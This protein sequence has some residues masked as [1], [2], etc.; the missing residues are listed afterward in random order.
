MPLNERQR[1]FVVAY[2]KTGIA[3]RS[4]KAAGYEVTSRNALDVNAS[5]LLRNDKIQSA[6]REKRRQMLKRSDITL[7]KLLSDIAEARALAMSSA[8]PS[9]AIAASQL[10]AKL[11][12]LLVDRKESGAPG[13]FA[14]L[15]TPQQV[16]DAI[17]AELG[18]AAADVLQAAVARPGDASVLP[19]EVDP[20]PEEPGPLPG[21]SIN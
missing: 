2:I 7:E 15:T 19:D 1:R 18:D 12:G 16:L 8:Q 11:V 14:I 5:R 3:S 6:I 13:D 10:S 4:Y 21:D 17:R 20:L 9:A